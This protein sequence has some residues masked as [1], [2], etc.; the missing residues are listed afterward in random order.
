MTSDAWL[1]TKSRGDAPRVAPH[2][3]VGQQE[4]PFITDWASHKK[5]VECLPL[6]LH[7]LMLLS[8]I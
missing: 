5:H 1:T 7:D 8:D 6:C 4:G 2:I 3:K